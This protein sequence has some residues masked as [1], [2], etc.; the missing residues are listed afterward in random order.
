MIYFFFLIIWY[1]RKF[2]PSFIYFPNRLFP[3]LGHGFRSIGEIKYT[4]KINEKVDH[5]Y[6]MFPGGF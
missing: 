5:N 1:I 3:L 2:I 4:Y 6:V